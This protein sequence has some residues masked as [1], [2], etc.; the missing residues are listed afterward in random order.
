MRLSL[1][2]TKRKPCALAAQHLILNINER[3]ANSLGVLCDNF[4]RIVGNSY[5]ISLKALG[6][7]ALYRYSFSVFANL[8]PEALEGMIGFD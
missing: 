2:F 6:F 5:Y 8:W 4:T 3:T 7:S 1:D